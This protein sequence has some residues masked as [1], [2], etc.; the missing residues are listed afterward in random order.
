MYSC[1]SISP[2]LIQA[3]AT[4]CPVAYHTLGNFIVNSM[5]SRSSAMPRGPANHLRMAHQIEQA[6]GAVDLLELL[7]PDLEHMRVGHDRP[8]VLQGKKHVGRVIQAPMP[9]QFD[10]A[11]AAAREP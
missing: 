3:S 5:N 6:A 7:L 4:S 1:F 10:R 2:D 9:G 8:R 11:R